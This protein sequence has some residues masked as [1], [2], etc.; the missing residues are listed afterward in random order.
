[1]GWKANSSSVL[2]QPTQWPRLNSAKDYSN[3]CED[4]DTKTPHFEAEGKC[5]PSTQP[6]SSN[7]NNSDASSTSAFFTT[8]YVSQF[9]KLPQSANS[10]SVET[11]SSCMGS[12]NKKPLGFSSDPGLLN[13]VYDR[14][15]TD[16]YPSKHVYCSRGPKF[17]RSGSSRITCKT[18]G[19][20][21]F[22]QLTTRTGFHQ[23]PFR[24][25][26]KGEGHRPVINLRR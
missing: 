6:L 24:G 13:R 9:C 8:R 11:F 2:K 10:R 17:D 22:T 1:M 19:L 14:T 3:Q 23:L 21:C 4:F 12:S 15:G 18:G 20:P 5:T 7:Q 26:Q 16:L 25:P